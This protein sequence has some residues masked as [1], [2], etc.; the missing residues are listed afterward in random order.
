MDGDVAMGS[1]TIADTEDPAIFFTPATSFSKVPRTPRTSFSRTPSTPQTPGSSFS[2]SFNDTPCPTN[3]AYRPLPGSLD[4][5]EGVVYTSPQQAQRD[6]PPVPWAPAKKKDAL[7]HNTNPATA[8]PTAALQA[9]PQPAPA[10][11][12][13]PAR[14]SRPSQAQV[15]SG[16][17]KAAQTQAGPV[18]K[19]AAASVPV[20]VT[21]DPAQVFKT[22]SWPM[23]IAS[24]WKTVQAL[25]QLPSGTQPW[26]SAAWAAF[27]ATN[28]PAQ[29]FKAPS[30]SVTIAS[31]WTTVKPL[32]HLLPGTQLWD[33][34]ASYY[35]GAINDPAKAFKTPSWSMTIAQRWAAVQTLP[36]LPPGTQVWELKSS[37]FP[38]VSQP[39]IEKAPKQTSIAPPASSLQSAKHQPTAPPVQSATDIVEPRPSFEDSMQALVG[40]LTACHVSHPDTWAW[41]EPSVFGLYVEDKTKGKSF[42][43]QL[44][45]MVTTMLPVSDSNHES[46][47]VE[48][49]HGTQQEVVPP[50]LSVPP[51]AEAIDSSSAILDAMVQEQL[52]EEFA[53]EEKSAV[54][55]PAQE[56]HATLQETPETASAGSVPTMNGNS[57]D[58][59]ETEGSPPNDEGKSVAVQGEPNPTASTGTFQFGNMPQ[60]FAEVNNPF[61]NAPTFPT[62]PAII[63]QPGDQAPL[64]LL[65]TVKEAASQEKPYEV[66][67]DD[68]PNVDTEFDFSKH[69]KRAARAPVAATSSSPPASTSP[70]GTPVEASSVQEASLAD[71]PP[72]SEAST[73]TETS[74]TD[75]GSTPAETPPSSL[76]SPA[77]EMA[78]VTEVSTPAEVSL[79]AETSP[80]PPLP[81]DP[82]A[83]ASASVPAVSI[84]FSAPPLPSG[85]LVFSA[86][87]PPPEPR[88]E[89]RGERKR[90]RDDRETEK[91]YDEEDRHTAKIS[92]YGWLPPA[93]E[94]VKQ[95]H[96]RKKAVV[97]HLNDDPQNGY[98]EEYGLAMME[99]MFYH[100]LGSVMVRV[101]YPPSDW[102]EEERED[103]AKCFVDSLLEEE[104][105]EKS[106]EMVLEAYEPR[107]GIK[108]PIC[109]EELIHVFKKWFRTHIRPELPYISYKLEKKER[110]ALVKPFED[111]IEKYVDDHPPRY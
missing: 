82:T 34:A 47:K 95:Q 50:S 7:S 30:W 107:F 32:A 61:I 55:Q 105:N 10:P 28:N 110:I 75:E 27:W 63:P 16:Q 57:D 46:N 31:L 11:Q 54:T 12:L 92:I 71:A 58:A 84:P 66:G 65:S 72:P 49:Q 88:G 6:Q 79:P 17:A 68:D 56:A 103:E 14:P 67:S 48:P 91:M 90:L 9:A 23:N 62:A 86:P 94:A 29:V 19:A 85:G 13:T 64:S 81:A 73:P 100:E 18:A 3:N 98:S 36:Q 99:H 20:W 5:M 15:A 33:A 39:S 77:A 2:Q 101:L 41:A 59:M 78:P 70:A 108:F 35:A 40:Q 22:P 69:F 42:Q 109:R 4:G 60:L 1:N 45:T 96:E 38:T 83:Q 106:F 111:A 104:L 37:T 52:L 80:T 97:A 89:P 25:P 102:T 74:S 44:A 87:S 53:S 8:Q 93:M 51:A 26:H 43:A 24:R 76:S 21:N